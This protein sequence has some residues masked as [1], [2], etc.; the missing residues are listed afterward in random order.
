MMETRGVKG[1]GQGQNEGLYCIYKICIV[2]QLMPISPVQIFVGREFVDLNKS[3][4]G[5]YSC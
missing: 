5:F 4:V 1:G 2:V 3:Q